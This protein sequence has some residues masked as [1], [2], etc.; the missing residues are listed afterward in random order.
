MENSAYSLTTSFYTVALKTP[1]SVTE[2]IESFAGFKKKWHYGEG[3]SFS[4]D[5]VNSAK[6]LSIYLYENLFIKLNVFPG[7]NGEI[8]IKTYFPKTAIEITINNNLQ[9]NYMIETRGG[10]ELFQSSEMSIADLKKQILSHR[11]LYFTEWNL[12]ESCRLTT[13]TKKTRGLPALRLETHQKN[14]EA[15][16]PFFVLNASQIIIQPFVNILE[17]STLNTPILQY[18]GNSIADYYQQD[19]SQS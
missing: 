5:V 9:A 13:T 4:K 12:L 10:D 17:V 6:E 19:I 16:F 7:L 14:S 1:N 11:Q 3:E 8:M 18:S 15:A 2:K